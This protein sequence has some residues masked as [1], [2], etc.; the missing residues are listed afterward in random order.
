MVMLP[1]RDGIR[2]QGLCLA[3]SAVAMIAWP[4]TAQLAERQTSVF[5][6]FVE[7][8]LPNDSWDG[9][10]HDLEATATFT[11][12]E[13]GETITTPMFYAGGESDHWTFRFTATQPGEWAFETSSDDPELDGKTGTVTADPDPDARGFIVGAGNQWAQ[14]LGDGTMVGIAPQLVMYGRDANEYRPEEVDQHVDL[15]LNQHGFT[16]LHISAI[17]GQWFDFD[18]KND[19]ET[20]RSMTDPDPRTFEALEMVIQKVREAGG[21]VHIWAWGDEQRGQTP[22]RLEDGIN[23]KVDRRLQRYIAARLGP[24]PGWTMGYGFDL[25]E[26][27]GASHS[28]YRVNDWEERINRLSGYPHLL[29][30]RSNGPN[31]TGNFATD[32]LGQDDIDWNSHFTYAGYEHQRPSYA[33]YVE[34]MNATT[35]EGKALDI[36]QFSEDRFRVRGRTKDYTEQETRR[37]MWHSMMAGG[38]ANIWGNLRANG[39]DSGG[40]SAP[41]TGDTPE[42]LRTW[43]TFWFDKNH[44]RLGMRPH[45]DLTPGPTKKGENRSIDVVGTVVLAD[46]DE[47]LVFYA[48]ETDAIQIDLSSLSGTFRVTAVDTT[49]PYQEVDL[50]TWSG[51]G[52]LTLPRTSDWA[53]ALTPTP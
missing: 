7:W 48:E 32:K 17:A 3:A 8:Q 27:A 26:W 53:V 30:G 31:R 1:R 16:G 20:D 23:G 19:V 25:N 24:V 46:G 52:D 33:E 2:V 10:P 18:R 28:P 14:Q 22:D 29:G 47:L 40:A 13:S 42:Q 41:Y 5:G 35:S 39:N 12:A 44:F 9:N 45:N 21:T 6:P 15:W 34:V 4:A 38:V 50:G 37:G 36:P 11:H 49:R 51:R 43:K